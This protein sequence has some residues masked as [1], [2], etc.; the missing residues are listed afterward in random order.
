MILFVIIFCFLMASFYMM[1]FD[2]IG[3]FEKN[4]V[5]LKDQIGMFF[6]LNFIW[7]VLL[8]LG[9]VSVIRCIIILMIK[10]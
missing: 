7:P 9:I 8:F 1:L 2:R 10:G 3:L 5:K 4:N 6:V